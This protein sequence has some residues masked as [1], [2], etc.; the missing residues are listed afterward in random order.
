[1]IQHL[2]PVIGCIWM[3]PINKNCCSWPNPTFSLLTMRIF[4]KNIHLMS[5][6][7]TCSISNFNSSIYNWNH[8]IFFRE[9]S[10]FIKRKSGFINS[11]VLKLSH[12]INICPQSVQRNI[13]ILISFCYI[14]KHTDIMISPSTL[15]KS[16]SP[17]RRNSRSSKI[18]MEF[19]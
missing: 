11:K 10:H 4:D 17:K 9:F 18:D 3:E 7:I 5:F 1:M 12:V 13:I 16:H 6:S 14:F 15:M 19:I 8:V 2:N